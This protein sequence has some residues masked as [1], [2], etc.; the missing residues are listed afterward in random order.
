MINSFFVLFY[1]MPLTGSFHTA[2]ALQR[3]IQVQR[4]APWCREAWPCICAFGRLT[5]RWAHAALVASRGNS[6]L[7]LP[8]VHCDSNC[9]WA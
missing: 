5:G 4:K 8:R 6:E 2:V 7:F 9:A 1:K 3:S